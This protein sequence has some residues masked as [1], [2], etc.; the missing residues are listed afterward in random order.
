RLFVPGSAD[1][2]TSPRPLRF[3][4][5]GVLLASA[6]SPALLLADGPLAPARPASGGGAPRAPARRA[7]RG[8][9]P[10][11]APRLR[12]AG[13]GGDRRLSAR[14][15]A[16]PRAPRMAERRP[17]PARHAVRG[18]RDPRGAGGPA[19][20]GRARGPR[21]AVAWGYVALAVAAALLAA[22]GRV[23]SALAARA[24][25]MLGGIAWFALGTLPLAW[26]WPDWN[27]WRNVTPSLGLGAAL[28]AALGAA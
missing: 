27:A 10:L 15:R 8:D 17:A 23:R 28:T 1:L 2:S 25:V 6:E 16:G 4:G 26:I 11:R 22:R 19:S 14:E 18:G 3:H 20:H 9:L 24:P 5:R 7:L 12:G 13:G 21:L